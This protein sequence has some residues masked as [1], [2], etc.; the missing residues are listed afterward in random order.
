MKTY[1][2]N[3]IEDVV[4]PS[5]K[6]VAL[7]ISQDS[8]YLDFND[9]ELGVP[10]IDS[11]LELSIRF[12]GNSF[13]GLFYNNIWDIDFIS[14]Y[15]FKNQMLSEEFS[16]NVEEIK[17][18][19]FQYLN[20]VFEAYEKYKVIAVN[21]EFDIHNIRNDFFLIFETD[22]I[23]VCVGGDYMNFYSNLERLDESSLKELSNQW[24]LYFLKYRLRKNVILKD[25]MCEKHLSDF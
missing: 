10:K 20:D 6:W 18:I 21:E 8:I 22:E 2:L 11:N 14:S 25:K 17:F 16:F 23:A 24:V 3:L 7:E 13:I 19:D 15:D 12:S 4:R 9:V 5:G 1:A